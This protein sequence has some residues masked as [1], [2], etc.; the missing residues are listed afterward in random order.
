MDRD[1]R[2]CFDAAASMLVQATGCQA[3]VAHQIVELIAIGTLRW[4]DPERAPTSLD[5]A[6]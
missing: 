4:V 2:E 1:A 3:S 6:I 5:Y